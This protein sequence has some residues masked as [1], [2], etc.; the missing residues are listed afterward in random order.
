VVRYAF[1][2]ALLREVVA[3]VA[4]EALR[5]RRHARIA[6]ALERVFPDVARREPE[7]LARHLEGAG[8]AD[9]AVAYR[10]DAA[11]LAARR[12]ASVEAAD[13]LARALADLDALPDG[14][15]R[16]DLELELRV[17][18]GN[19]LLSSRGYAAPEVADTYTRARALCARSGEDA[20]LLPVLYGQWV[21]A[22]VRSQHERALAI[23]RELRALAE[24]L[25]TGVLSV[26][27]RA[28]GWPLVCMGRCAEARMHLDRVRAQPD[29]RRPPLRRL[30]GQDPAVAGL[31]TGAWALWGCGDARAAAQR[32]ELA[33]GLARDLGHPVSVI[34]ALGAGALLAAFAGDAFAARERAAEAVALCDEFTVPLWRAWSAYAL[35]AAELQEGDPE[36]AAA[37]LRAALKAAR[38][39]GA[40]LFEPYALTALA[41]AAARVG[42]REAALRGLEAAAAIAGRTRELLWQPQTRRALGELA[43]LPG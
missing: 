11:R 25:D 35:G 41:E 18:Q 2:H 42:R 6:R 14:E 37:T 13:Q 36:R 21:N 38:A 22:F 17:A 15:D 39:T 43:V 20:R 12:S 1:R 8:A 33:I 4:S 29:D 31:A 40:V 10:F 23:G 5:R 3:Q 34:Y 32:A 28:V 9:R 26:A 19:A 16:D 27:E 7:T 30:Y 24:R